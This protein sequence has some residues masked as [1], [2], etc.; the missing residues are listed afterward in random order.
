MNNFYN[1]T[2]YMNYQNNQYP[3]AGNNYNPVNNYERQNQNNNELL[4]NLYT[5]YDGF[6]RGNMFTNLYD[7]Y[8]T[9]RPYEIKPMNR[10]AEMLTNID[11]L[12]FAMIDINLYLDVHPKNKKLIK[13]FNKIQKQ[14]H[15]LLMEYEREFGPL[16]VTNN[17]N[18]NY[19]AWVENPWPW[20]TR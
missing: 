9:N 1:Y 16:L 5:P 7:S 6:I 13:E 2:D 17:T 4:D 8:K 10:Q 11:A 19:W 20:E 3:I 18:D 15:E 12:T 14:K